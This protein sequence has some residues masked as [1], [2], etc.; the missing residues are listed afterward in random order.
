[1]QLSLWSKFLYPLV[2]MFPGFKT[3][4]HCFNLILRKNFQVW[5]LRWRIK[6]N[7]ISPWAGDSKA[8]THCLTSPREKTAR[9]LS[10]QSTF[11]FSPSLNLIVEFCDLLP[12]IYRTKRRA[13]KD[14]LYFKCCSEEKNS[15]KQDA[16]CML[17]CSN[18]NQEFKRSHLFWFY[19]CPRQF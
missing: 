1:M 5:F 12:L 8:F 14:I 11:F 6:H 13:S 18:A 3:K 7:F 15:T 16:T 4:T 19:S 2:M 10:W 17:S 9:S